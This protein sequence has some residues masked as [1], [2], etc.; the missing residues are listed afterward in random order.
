ML[1]LKN[2]YQV[3]KELSSE[4]EDMQDQWEKIKEAITTCQE[5]MVLKKCQEKVWISAETLHKTEE[6]LQ[7][8]A[9]IN[10]HH[11]RATMA[12]SQ[13]EYTKVSR[14][15]KKSTKKENYIDSLAK[16]A[17]EAAAKGNMKELYK[18]NKKLPGKINQPE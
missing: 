16:E 5:V 17:E 15:L 7:K 13:Q 14:K 12:N 1:N 10:N 2:R 9:E 8:K 3:L 18:T 11:T 6:R 4:E